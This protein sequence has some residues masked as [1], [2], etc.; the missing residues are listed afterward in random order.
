VPLRNRLKHSLEPFLC[1]ENVSWLRKPVELANAFEPLQDGRIYI[2]KI[3]G[4]F[5]TQRR[6]T[7][8]SSAYQPRRRSIL[9]IN[10][11]RRASAAPMALSVWRKV[12]TFEP[13]ETIP[14]STKA[15]DP[16]AAA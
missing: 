11:E 9:P 12:L 15:I 2:E 3:N 8:A 10:S 14:P 4:P 16:S 5:L 13:S 1:Q 7:S 6:V